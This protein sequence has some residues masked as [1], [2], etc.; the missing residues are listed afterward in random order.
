MLN[1][2]IHSRR[3]LLET[4]KFQHMIIWASWWPVRASSCPHRDSASLPHSHADEQ[5]GRSARIYPPASKWRLALPW[6]CQW[7]TRQTRSP[8][9]LPVG[10]GRARGGGGRGGKNTNKPKTSGSYL[11]SFFLAGFNDAGRDGVSLWDPIFKKRG[12]IVKENLEAKS[13][14]RILRFCSDFTKQTF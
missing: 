7:A 14:I 10:R 6:V 8:T 1:S 4:V 13:I 2:T 3:Q 5:A 11:V 12:M 9:F